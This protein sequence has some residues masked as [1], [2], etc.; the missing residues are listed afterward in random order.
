MAI[1]THTLGKHQNQLQMTIW[2]NQL[3]MISLL[4]GIIWTWVNLMFQ[5][6]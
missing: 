1:A 2:Q 6:F 5:A 4:Y 3:N